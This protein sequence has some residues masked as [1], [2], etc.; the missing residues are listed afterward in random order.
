MG[1]W[2]R[3]VMGLGLLLFLFRQVDWPKVR[4]VLQRAN[5][6]AVGLVLLI[7]VVVLGIS[8]LR[9]RT[10][11]RTHQIDLTLGDLY[12]LNM[13]SWFFTNFLPT[14]TGGDAVRAY[15]AAKRTGRTP[16][17]LS[18]VVIELV[19]GG[20]AL[21]SIGLL[22]L[23]FNLDLIEPAWLMSLAMPVTLLGILILCIPAVLWGAWRLY[24]ALQRRWM[25]GQ[26]L[27]RL[28]VRGLWGIDEFRRVLRGYR[29]HWRPLVLCLFLSECMHLLTV[30]G[31][32]IIYRSVGIPVEFL[33][34]AFLLP[35]TDLA[36]MIPLSINGL[37]IREL[38]TVFL[39][40][41]VG[42]SPSETV[43]AVL[44][45]RLCFLCISAPGGL[46]YLTNRHMK[47]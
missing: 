26:S 38:V 12:K 45:W 40:V 2:F 35:V 17:V 32:F 19:S 24:L 47:G 3:L 29:T 37:G 11:L 5:P 14:T 44:L 27:P 22:A 36:S 1:F 28:V 39:L 41:P 15:F 31:Y 46:V 16:E 21:L 13:V 34:A 33:R 7:F 8:S 25:A 20:I 42:L 6:V 43:A 23:P 10:L 18:S 4:E 30:V 9:W